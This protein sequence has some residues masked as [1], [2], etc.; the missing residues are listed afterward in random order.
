MYSIVYFN[1]YDDGLTDEEIEQQVEAGTYD[2]NTVSN[3]EIFYNPLD[4][5]KRIYSASI[6][7]KENEP[8]VFTV[9]IDENHFFYEKLYSYPFALVHYF[10]VFKG[11]D[12]TSD[13]DC[14]FYGRLVSYEKSWNNR[15]KLTCEGCLAFLKDNFSFV[16]NREIDNS[17]VFNNS[18]LNKVGLFPH[19]TRNIS[20]ANGHETYVSTYDTYERINKTPRKVNN[21]YVDGV[22]INSAN[23]SN[24]FMERAEYNHFD[25]EVNDEYKM[26][27][28][29]ELLQKCAN[30]IDVKAYATFDRSESSLPDYVKGI[31]ENTGEVDQ[32]SGYVGIHYL[33]QYRDTNIKIE[34][35][36]NLLDF[37][38]SIS[39]DGT[40]TSVFTGAY[41]GNNEID[42]SMYYNVNMMEQYGVIASTKDISSE[43]ER[44]SDDSMTQKEIL[45]RMISSQ[46]PTRSL[47]IS[48]LDLSRFGLDGEEIRLY[49]NVHVISKPHHMDIELP[50]T[51]INYDLLDAKNSTIQL[52]K[53][54]ST[55]ITDYVKEAT[56]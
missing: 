12:V 54:F 4:K 38:D 19:A 34:F 22:K 13:D 40:F 35:G 32:D 27:T 18:L 9:E 1:S 44:Y 46:I 28:N 26:F 31:N 48:F 16:T 25:M 17:T 21:F 23:I 41:I 39:E 11:S 30:A 42:T 49:D 5:H 47:N 36:K 3:D 2:V 10:K 52:G 51:E 50:V 55:P 43:L 45:D 6:T 7:K 24:Y 53:T 15:L 56:Q 20:T 33:T 37:T 8:D 14:V 29:L